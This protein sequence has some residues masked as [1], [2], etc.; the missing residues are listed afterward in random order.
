MSRVCAML[1]W[2]SE[3]LC[4]CVI[5]ANKGFATLYWQQLIHDIYIDYI[6]DQKKA[7]RV[8]LV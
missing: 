6:A 3:F 1:Q 4:N 7:L 2:S 8:V 5:S